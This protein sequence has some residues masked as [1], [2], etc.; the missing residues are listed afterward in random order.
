MI[1]A[2]RVSSAVPALSV[3]DIPKARVS[4]LAIARYMAISLIESSILLYK[5]GQVC[6]R[7]KV[8]LLH[9]RGATRPPE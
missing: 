2:R 9:L 5:R 1:A 7:T 8:M 3:V 6:S 4:C